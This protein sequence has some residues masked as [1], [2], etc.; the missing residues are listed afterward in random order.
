M[1][2]RSKAVL[3]MSAVSLL[4]A[5]EAGHGPDKSGQ[6]YDYRGMRAVQ[7]GGYLDTKYLHIKILPDETRATK[8]AGGRRLGHP[9]LVSAD[10]GASDARA[11]GDA[12]HRVVRGGPLRF[13][14]H[15]DASPQRTAAGK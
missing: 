7:L 8:K 11:P 2:I 3:F 1:S 6:H 12:Q 13:R 9:P 5:G 15:G 10:E 4:G 14:D